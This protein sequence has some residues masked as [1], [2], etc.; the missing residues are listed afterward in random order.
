MLQVS[1]ADYA[2]Y[3]SLRPLLRAARARGWDVSFAC[4]DG[5]YASQLR[6]EGFK[7]WAVPAERG[8]SPLAHGRAVAVL[9]G[10]M[11]RS[12]PDIVHTHTPIGGLVGR[13]AAVAVGHRRIVHTLH[14]LPFD[15]HP[16][17]IGD[18]VFLLAERALG[19]R[20]Q[21]LLSQ[22]NA[23]AATAQRLGIGRDVRVI[24]NGVD[25]ARFAPDDR[26]REATRR[27]LGVA[28]ENVVVIC[29]A[30]LVR[31]KGLLELASAAYA[32][33]DRPELVF[34]IVG[35][36]EPSDRSHLEDALRSHP[37]ARA[38]GTRWQLLG[39][40][41]DVP[42]LLRASDLFVLPSHREGLPRSIIE[43]MAAGLPIVA[44]DLPG[45]RELVRHDGNGLTVPKG[46][47][48]ALAAAIVSLLDVSRR[49]SY[50]A[51]SREIAVREHEERA[52]LQRQ[53]DLIAERF[54]DSWPPP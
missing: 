3:Y 38:L 22:S 26:I 40:R 29:V 43:A 28:A 54:G 30:R 27:A 2:A 9:A 19:A 41:D 34:L 35:R 25:T 16:T 8:W 10:R 20:T 52:V 42:A 24:G 17:T 46:D 1:A 7:H 39:V 31:E 51:A 11:R 49:R 13:S 50:G 12:M 53:L 48:D 18:R 4:A 23:D 33:A 14:G 32:L 15:T 5:E 44:T 21:L 47:A 36:S 6:A 37:A 45:C